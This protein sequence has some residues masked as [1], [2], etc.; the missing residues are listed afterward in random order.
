MPLIIPDTDT[1]TGRANWD[2]Q[3]YSSG[4]TYKRNEYVRHKQEN[5]IYGVYICNVPDGIQTPEPWTPSHWDYLF[6]DLEQS[7]GGGGSYSTKTCKLVITYDKHGASG[8][9]PSTQT[10]TYSGEKKEIALKSTVQ[11]QGNMTWSGHYFLGWSESNNATEGDVR[12]G[13]VITHTWDE[14]S[15]GTVTV[16]LKAVWSSTGRIIYKPDQN[17]IE[18]SKEF[19]DRYQNLPSSG[20]VTLAD[21]VAER[22]FSRKGYTISDWLRDGVHFAN[23]QETISIV[24]GMGPEL[25]LYP[26]WR[27]LK[28]NITFKPNDD[29]LNAS[30]ITINNVSFDSE[31]TMLDSTAFEKEGY[32]VSFWNE[33]ADGTGAIWYPGKTYL[34]TTNRN[35]TLYAQWAGDEHRISYRLDEDSPQVETEYSIA[36]YGSPFYTDYRPQAK[37]NR[38]FAGWKTSG[39]EILIKKDAWMDA[40]CLP[41]L[42]TQLYDV[43][44]ATFRR[45]SDI[46]LYP[47]WSDNYPFGK[48]FFGRKESTDYGIIINEPPIYTWPEKPYDHKNIRGKHGDIIIDSDYYKNVSKKYTIT[49]YVK[50]DPEQAA[51]NVSDFLHRYNGYK[52]YIRLEDSYEPDVYML[53][54]YEEFNNLE[55]IF[56]Q[57]WK[58]E[59]EF[60][61][62][63]QKYLLTGDRRIDVTQSGTLINNPTN[64]PAFPI[65]QIWGTG[66]IHFYGRP[67]RVYEAGKVTNSDHSAAG[68]KDVP[69]SVY[70]N[71]NRISI[72]AETLNA[73][74]INGKDQ[75]DNV[76]FDDRIVLYPGGNT[77]TYQGNIEKISIIPRW[78]RL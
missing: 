77:I 58:A 53:G 63:P 30:D 7:S 43:N 38:A 33:S 16:S 45:M 41:Q 15:S 59:I 49:G 8:S 54:I 65:V 52:N 2:I 9:A 74:D 57:A 66:T 37:D 75:N 60:N 14:A 42:D 11:D 44:D 20:T 72:D 3:I 13:T 23:R 22:M 31:V 24:N 64:Y 29:S 26:G 76:Y 21:G 5:G 17:A 1:G 62:K 39:G 35:V 32:H 47:I 46:V 12:P 6:D 18:A 78:W 71:F 67:T 34:Y 10:V 40:Y 50:D 61:C 68:L 27:A 69:V 56:G 4:S 70:S 55:S 25:I 19:P 36:T 51:K 28:Y 48:L 73:T